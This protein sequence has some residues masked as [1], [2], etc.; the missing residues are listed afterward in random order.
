MINS[1]FLVN[2][3]KLQL[4]NIAPS[5]IVMSDSDSETCALMSDRV[6]ETDIRDISDNDSDTR[7]LMS[8]VNS[9]TALMSDSN[10]MIYINNVSQQFWDYS[11][12]IYDGRMCFDIIKLI[13]NTIIM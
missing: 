8:S 13:W 4:Y 5:N 6:S 1:L 7:T 3:V 12:I 2:L 10:D 9:E 11:V